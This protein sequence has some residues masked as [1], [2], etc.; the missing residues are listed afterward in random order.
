MTYYASPNSN[1]SLLKFT[2][3]GFNVI[4]QIYIHVYVYM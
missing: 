2:I 4:L 1:H 3:Q